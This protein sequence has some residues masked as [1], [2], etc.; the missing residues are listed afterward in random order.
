MNLFRSSKEALSVYFSNLS[1]SFRG[2]V[3]C[4]L[5]GALSPI[6]DAEPVHIPDPHLRAAVALALKKEAGAPIT[7]ADMAS[8]EALEALKSDI[9]D[10]TGIEFATNLTKLELGDNRI[11]DV[12]PLKKLTNLTK[13]R[14]GANHKIS[15]VS[16]LEGLTNLTFLD[17]DS[18][19]ISDVSPLKKLTNLTWLDLDDNGIVDISPLEELTNLAYLDLDG[20]RISDISPLE[21]LT[22]LKFLD[23]DENNLSNLSPLSA[24]INL[25]VLD[26]EGNGLSDVSALSTLTNLTELDLHNN[27]IID[28]SPLKN[29]TKLRILDI[30]ENHITDF[31]PIAGLIENLVEYNNSHQT[32]PS[33]KAEDVNRDGIVNRTDLILVALNYRNAD[34]SDSARFGVYPDVNTDGVVDIKDLVAVTAAI[35]TG[36]AAPGVVRNLSGHAV[37]SAENLTM[38]LHLAKRLDTE[39]PRTQKGI[40]FLERL[41]VSLHFRSMLPQETV[42]LANYPNPFNPETWIPYQL[43]KPAVVRITLYSADGKR[44]RVLDLGA[45]PA[46]AYRSKSRAA[47][48]DG[49]NDLGEPVASGVYFYELTAGDFTATRK[50]VIRK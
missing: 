8:L 24:L 9:R 43:A 35:N 38:W 5:L 28:V 31:S 7:P 4:I 18:N 16:P 50:M 17:I 26:I 41:L 22:N 15:D 11:S 30:S 27:Q 3:M 12:S 40:A 42:L 1:L 39:D 34:F 46:G 14:L 6:V 23:L 19:Q 25:T 48:W 45:L 2:V 20:N 10:L 49:R 47:Y 13:L 44:V 32:A 21:G 33:V 37:L 29:M 36:A